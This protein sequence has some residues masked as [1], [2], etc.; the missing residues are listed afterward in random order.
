M[1]AAAKYLGAQSI[2]MCAPGHQAPIRQ[3]LIGGVLPHCTQPGWDASPSHYMYL[4]SGHDVTRRINCFTSPWIEC[5]TVVHHWT[6]SM[7]N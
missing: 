4:Y 7:G 6:T 1:L 2:F 3:Q 5:A